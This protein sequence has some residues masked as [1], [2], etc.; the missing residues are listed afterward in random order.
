[1]NKIF[2]S[3]MTTLLDVTKELVN[4]IQDINKDIN[5]ILLQGDIGSG[6]T[7][8]VQK[9]TSLFG[10]DNVT[11]PTFSIMHEYSCSIFHYDLYQKSWNE[12]LSLG[13]IEFLLQK[14]THFIEWPTKELKDTLCQLDIKPIEI[15]IKD[16]NINNRKYEM[17]I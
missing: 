1:M 12:L 8:F 2:I 6:K 5:I 15:N 3:N 10:N 14:G 11:S 9:Y 16:E 7:T 13:V 4:I 17:K